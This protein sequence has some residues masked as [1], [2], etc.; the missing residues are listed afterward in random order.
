MLK[1][2][3]NPPATLGRR[4]WN[5]NQRRS[6]SIIART[7]EPWL[8]STG[9]KTMEGKKAVSR[10]AVKYGM[11]SAETK[12]FKKLL[13][14]QSQMLKR[15]KAWAR[16]ELMKRRA[17]LAMLKQGITLEEYKEMYEAKKRINSLEKAQRHNEEIRHPE[18]AQRPEGSPLNLEEIPRLRST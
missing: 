4:A 6:Q 2:K 17:V 5:D 7:R 11:H 13:R 12:H 10:N 14:L 1:V 9:P 15:Y 3:L 8:A 16:I 18:R